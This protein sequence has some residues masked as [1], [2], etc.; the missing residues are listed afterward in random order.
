M[1]LSYLSALK[2]CVFGR[3]VTNIFVVCSIHFGNPMKN[4]NIYS[5]VQVVVFLFGIGLCGGL[6]TH[7]GILE[8]IAYRG[9]LSLLPHLRHPQPHWRVCGMNPLQCLIP[10]QSHS[11]KAQIVHTG[12]EVS[13]CVP[14]LYQSR[15]QW[16]TGPFL[17]TSL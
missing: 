16:L 3:V 6:K 11:G 1:E 14:R 10:G 17:V 15:E 13:T 9:L 2:S 5:L 8:W 4:K 12:T 7:F